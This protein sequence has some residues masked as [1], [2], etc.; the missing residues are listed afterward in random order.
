MYILV[1]AFEAQIL[2]RLALFSGVMNVAT[3]EG[4]NSHYET[5]SCLHVLGLGEELF[6][7]GIP[8]VALRSTVEASSNGGRM[9]APAMVAWRGV[10]AT[11]SLCVNISANQKVGRTRD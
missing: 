7:T 6:S 1:D 3:A 10:K 2:R 9:S 11:S 8:V 5:Y 4:R